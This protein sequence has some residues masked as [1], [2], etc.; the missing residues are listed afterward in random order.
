MSNQNKLWKLFVLISI[1]AVGYIFGLSWETIQT[2]KTFITKHF[3]KVCTPS[4]WSPGDIVAILTIIT[5]L[6]IYVFQKIGSPLLTSKTLLKSDIKRFFDKDT[7]EFSTKY[8]IEPDC[9]NMDPAQEKE[10]GDIFSSNPRKLFTAV[11]D[12]LSKDSRRYLLILADSGMGKT[13]FFLNYYARNL[14]RAKRKQRQIAIIPLSIK[15]PDAFIEKIENK[16][17]T[18]LFLD[19]F[20]EDTLAIVDHRERIRELMNK[21]NHFKQVVITCRTQF[22][23][24]DEEIPKEVD[25]IIKVGPRKAGEGS[26]YEFYKI[27]LSPLTDQQV[28]KYLKRYYPWQFKKRQRAFEIVKKIPN[29]KV[30]PMLLSYIPDIIEADANLMH[31]AQLYDIMIEKWLERE[32][33][34]VKKEDL[35]RFSEMLAVDIFINKSTR[36]FERIPANDLGELANQ[37]QIK[38]ENWQITGRSLLNRDAEGNYKFSHRSIMEYL[39]VR[40][41]LKMSA[42]ERPMVDWTDQMKMFCL[43][44]SA[45][46]TFNLAKAQMINSIGIEFVFI[47]PGIF[48]MGTSDDESERGNDE[49]MHTVTLSKGFLMATAPV[50]HSQWQKVMGNN[51]SHFKKNGNNCPVEQVSWK[52]AQQFIDKLNKMEQTNKYCLPTE[53]Q[54]EY[55]CRAGSTTQYCFGDDE[56]MLNDYAWYDKNSGGKTHPV[57]QKKPNAWGLY[58]MHGNVWE[59][60]EDWYGDYPNEPVTDPTGPASGGNRVVRGGSWSSYPRDLRSAD[61]YRYSPGNRNDNVGFRLLRTT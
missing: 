1:L 30:R 29:L 10:P 22:F 19:A 56:K 31:T 41:F 6:S 58:D 53:A 14:K 32:E 39:F 48:T 44:M 15:D 7:I 20:D 38:L 27:Y 2:I 61:R 43:E 49:I 37:W 47:P 60:C 12:Y 16:S 51:P 4:E 36:G 42:D 21:C 24:K 25:G 35:L 33:R 28:S 17:E 5:S 3:T 26:A 46:K 18:I 40:S 23:P 57:K 34:W 13:S 45:I 50:T 11:D 9:T 54:W 52:D 8:Y 59:W 55:A